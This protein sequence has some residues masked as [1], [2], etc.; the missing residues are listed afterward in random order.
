MIFISYC[1]KGSCPDE[2]LKLR[3][4]IEDEGFMCVSDHDYPPESPPPDGWATWMAVNISQASLCLII[5]SESYFEKFRDGV[6]DDSYGVAFERVLLNDMFYKCLVLREPH[7]I[8]SIVLD[9]SHKEFI[10]PPFDGSAVLQYVLPDERTRLSILLNNRVNKVSLSRCQ[11]NIIDINDRGIGIVCPKDMDEKERKA[12]YQAIDC[13]I[14]AEM[15]I[16]I[17]P[18][19]DLKRY[20]G[21]NDH[22]KTA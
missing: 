3:R 15:P 1:R 16:T 18:A 13:L 9:E 11:D 8:V 2:V 21:G 20:Y 12:V 10:H 7:K 5:W 19:K 22:G 6:Q 4:S 17:V 14:Q